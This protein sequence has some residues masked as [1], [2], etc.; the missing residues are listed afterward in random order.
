[1]ETF[2]L[3]VYVNFRTL[4]RINFNI[5]SLPINLL[6]YVLKYGFTNKNELRLLM[7]GD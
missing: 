6:D 4:I 2:K 3:D 7:N 5:P 1:M